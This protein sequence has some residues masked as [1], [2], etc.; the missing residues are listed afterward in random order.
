VEEGHARSRDYIIALHSCLPQHM[1]NR[2]EGEGRARRG[3]SDS[4]AQT[5]LAV[6]PD[7]GILGSAREEVGVG[8]IMGA[9]LL[10][11]GPV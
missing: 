8:R 1:S 6:L 4:A 7:R 11:S 2:K 9:E 10:Q 3:R 5:S